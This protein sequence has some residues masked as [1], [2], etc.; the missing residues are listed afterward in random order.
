[1]STVRRYKYIKSNKNKKKESSPNASKNV[2][3]DDLPRQKIFFNPFQNGTIW[4]FHFRNVTCGSSEYDMYMMYTSL[5]FDK[6]Q[7]P[8]WLCARMS[9]SRVVWI[10][11][12]CF[13]LCIRPI[14]NLSLY[15]E[16]CL[17]LILCVFETGLF[18]CF[19]FIKTNRKQRENWK[20]WNVIVIHSKVFDKFD[21]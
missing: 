11:C 7:Q 12:M 21:R 15:N 13:H 3:T 2:R 1:M 9:V 8:W 19:T 4:W 20:V 10:F 14:S 5:N 17:F 6:W 16:L 18:V